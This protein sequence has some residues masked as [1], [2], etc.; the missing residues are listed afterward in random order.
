MRRDSF[1]VA[2]RPHTVY[3]GSSGRLDLFT[4]LLALRR[5]KSFL[6]CGKKISFCCGVR[7]GF[8]YVI[9]LDVGLFACCALLYVGCLHHWFARAVRDR[10]PPM[11]RLQKR[12]ILAQRRVLALFDLVRPNAAER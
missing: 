6:P 11:R 3:C 10:F 9:R 5:A 2:L 1:I 8:R 4:D 12:P 7:T